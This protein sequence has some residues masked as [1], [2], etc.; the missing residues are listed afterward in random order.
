MSCGAPDVNNRTKLCCENEVIPRGRI[1]PRTFPIKSISHTAET[2][3]IKS[4]RHCEVCRICG[5]KQ[6][7]P[8]ACR[9]I[10]GIGSIRSGSQAATVVA[11]TVTV[12]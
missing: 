4:I 10:D 7:K 8:G 11:K 12:R 3:G 5:L 9:N 6:S 1:Q 2:H